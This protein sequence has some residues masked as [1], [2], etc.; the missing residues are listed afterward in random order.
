MKHENGE[1][2]KCYLICI[3]LEQPPVISYDLILHLSGYFWILFSS[4]TGFLFKGLTNFLTVLITVKLVCIMYYWIS[5][6]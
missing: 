6:Y 5:N 1:I 3:L 4:E 2:L